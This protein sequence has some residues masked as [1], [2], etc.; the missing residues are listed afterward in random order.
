MILA[1][2]CLLSCTKFDID[3]EQWPISK[4]GGPSEEAFQKFYVDRGWRSDITYTIKD[5]RVTNENY[6]STYIGEVHLT[7]ILERMN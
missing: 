3:D 2:I 6:Y 1:G 4:Y 7:I 5:G